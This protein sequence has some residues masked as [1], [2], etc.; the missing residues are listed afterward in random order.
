MVLMG[1]FGGKDGGGIQPNLAELW[2]I[3]Y[4]RDSSAQ[5]TPGLF[6]FYMY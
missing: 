3:A 4:Q 5:S 2:G 1:G 6:L